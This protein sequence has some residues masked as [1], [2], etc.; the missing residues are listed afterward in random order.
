MMGKIL[1]LDK[2][3]KKLTLRTMVIPLGA[4]YVF[5]P[6]DICRYEAKTKI[7]AYNGNVEVR[8]VSL[9]LCSIHCLFPTIRR[10]VRREAYNMLQIKFQEYQSE[11]QQK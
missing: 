11:M 9:N 8:G 3:R 10:R 2:W 1:L 7:V 6:C 5:V 4:D